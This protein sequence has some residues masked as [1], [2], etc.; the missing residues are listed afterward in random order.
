MSEKDQRAALLWKILCAV[1]IAVASCI[2]TSLSPLLEPAAPGML[3]DMRADIE[4]LTAR[5]EELQSRKVDKDSVSMSPDTLRWLTTLQRS[6]DI[7]ERRLDRFE[8]ATEGARARGDRSG[9]DGRSRRRD[10]D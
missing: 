7:H 3:R 5:V 1:A 2:A 10:D 8:H 6:V 4:R 9:S